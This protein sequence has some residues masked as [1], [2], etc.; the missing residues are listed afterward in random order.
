[1]GST[2]RG[3]FEL[4]DRASNTLRKIEA[5][6]KKTQAAVVGVGAALDAQQASSVDSAKGLEKHDAALRKVSG[7]SGD[8]QKMSTRQ[9]TSEQKLTRETSKGTAELRRRDQELVKLR[10]TWGDYSKTTADMHRVGGLGALAGGILGTVGGPVGMFA[11]AV[12]G[13]AVGAGS[14]S[15]IGQFLQ[16]EQAAKHVKMAV[17]EMGK[18]FAVAGNAISLLKLGVVV[19][20]IA[21]LIASVTALGGGLIAF[22]PQ[23]ATLGNALYGLP[24]AFSA[25]IQGM[26]TFKLAI[27]GVSSAIGAA[28]Q[29]QNNW[30]IDQ[31]QFGLQVQQSQDSI[32]ASTVNL[33]NAIFAQNQAQAQLTATRRDAAR[34]LVDMEF[35]A[36]SAVLA[37]TQ[38]GLNIMQARQQLQ[39]DMSS[40]GTSQ[41]TVMQD[42]LGLQQ[43]ILGAQKQQVDTNRANKDLQLAKSGAPSSDVVMK[44]KEAHQALKMAMF[45][46]NEAQKQLTIAQKQYA[47]QIKLGNAGQSA[48][49]AQLRQLPASAKQFVQFIRQGGFLKAFMQLRN[50]AGSEFFPGLER[51]L[52]RLKGSLPTITRIV[53][54]TGRVLG[55]MF[56]NVISQLSDPKW[57]K[58]VGDANV[59]IL[60]TFSDAIKHFTSALKPLIVAFQPFIQFLVNAFDKWAKHKDAFYNSAAGAKDLTDKVKKLETAIHHVVHVF[61]DLWDI[62]RNI[63]RVAN[64]ALG[65]T[66]WNGATS[67]LDKLKKWTEDQQRAG[68]KGSLF[69]WFKSL[70]PTLR[71]FK[72]VLEDI[73]KAIIQ[74]S[75]KQGQHGAT[76]LLNNLDKLVKP[77]QTILVNLA[78]QAPTFE[79]IA[80]SM[81]KMAASLTKIHG[82]IPGLIALF[83]GAKTLTFITHLTRAA[84]ALGGL[85]G[86]FKTFQNALKALAGAGVAGMASPGTGITGRFKGLQGASQVSTLNAQWGL[87]SVGGPGS[88]E[89]PLVVMMK[90]STPTPGGDSIVQQAE[91]DAKNAAETGGILGTAK[92][93]FSDFKDVAKVATPPAL[94]AAGL[95]AVG[96]KLT[97]TLS[98]QPSHSSSTQLGANTS[99]G[100]YSPGMGLIHNIS[101]GLTAVGSGI[102]SVLGSPSL[103]GPSVS[104]GQIQK[105]GQ[106]AIAQFT[107]DINGGKMSVHQAMVS[108]LAVVQHDLGTLSPAG[109][110]ILSAAMQQMGAT[111]TQQ[112]TKL[113]QPIDQLNSYIVGAFQNTST[114]VQAVNQNIL[115]NSGKQWVSIGNAI[116]TPMNK[117]VTAVNAAIASIQGSAVSAL[118]GMGYSAA[119]AKKLISA[120]PNAPAGAGVA[121]AVSTNVP[122]LTS[123]GTVGLATG[124]RVMGNNPRDVYALGGNMVGGGELVVNRHQEQDVNNR[125]MRAGEPT[126]G[127]IVSNIK[128]PNWFASGGRI[129]QGVAAALNPYVYPLPGFTI[130]RTDMGVDASAPAGTPILALGDSKL[131]DVLQNWY[132]QQ[133]LLD[134]ALTNGPDQGKYWYVAEQITPVTE[135]IGA[136]FKAGQAV[137]HFAAS[138]TGI[139]MGWAGGP[140]GQT[141]AQSTGVTNANVHDHANT[142]AGLAFSAFLGGL[143]HGQLVSGGPT[144]GTGGS[145]KPF[146][147]PGLT[148][149]QIAGLSGAPLGLAQGA[150][151]LVAGG[152]NSKLKGW[153]KNAPGGSTP[154]A[155]SGGLPTGGGAL[156]SSGGSGTPSAAPISPG[157]SAIPTT[158]TPT[159][160]GSVTPES[161]SIAVLKGLGITPTV[162]NVY[163]MTAWIHQ[164]GGAGP[165]FGTP[166]NIANYNPLNTTQVEPGYSE[167]GAV[168][169]NIGSYVSWK[170]G[171][172]ATIK[173]LSY[174]GYTGVIAALKKG[175]PLSDFSNAVSSS[176]WG[177][178]GINAAGTQ[179]SPKALSTLASSVKANS[180]TITPTVGSG[181][182]ASLGN[183]AAGGSTVRAHPTALTVGSGVAGALAP[184]GSGIGSGVTAALAKYASQGSGHYV[185]PIPGAT[186]ERTDMGLDAAYSTA[187]HPIVAIGDSKVIG[188]SPNWY[189]GQPYV[190]FQFLDGPKKGQNYYIAEAINPTVQAGDIVKAGQQVG[191]YNLGGTG[192]ELGW[193][194]PALGTTLAASLSQYTYDGKVTAAGAAF[195]NFFTALNLALPTNTLPS[196][197]TVFGSFGPLPAQGNPFSLQGFVGTPNIAAVTQAVTAPLVHAS[198]R[199]L[200]GA[201]ATTGVPPGTYVPPPPP[202]PTYTPPAPVVPPHMRYTTT[203]PPPPPP[204][205]PTPTASPVSTIIQHH[206]PLASGGRVGGSN[207]RDVYA[208]GGNMVGGGELVV[209]RHQEQDVNSRLLRAGEPTIGSIVANK[210][211]PHWFAKGGRTGS[212]GTAIAEGALLAGMGVPRDLQKYNHQYPKHLTNTPGATIPPGDIAKIAQWAGMPGWTMSQISHGESSYMPGIVEWPPERGTGPIPTGAQGYGLWQI[213]YARHPG[214]TGLPV[215]PPNPNLMLNPLINAKAAKNL[216]D[217]RGVGQW[218]GKGFMTNANMPYTGRLASGGRVRSAG[219]MA[220]GGSF[221]TSGPTVLGVGERNREQVTVTPLGAGGNRPVH[222]EIHRI[223]VNREGDIQK[224]VDEELRLLAERFETHQ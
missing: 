155:F 14:Q 137:A 3:A 80:V 179:L 91:K 161:F 52:N 72:K 167:T 187:N 81:A 108:V 209:N 65:N 74:M 44:L 156:P 36:K 7:S 116:L 217:S 160:S 102:Q 85:A 103:G 59:K 216:Y 51:G 176:P 206:V 186:L 58:K 120:G 123:V 71:A 196:L 166:N 154:S 124:G 181:V 13:G 20:A 192:L 138:G 109:Q 130:G 23:I 100:T 77:L 214:S 219:W 147:I 201:G 21:P 79:K 223:E 25:A 101:Q 139:E 140:T 164:E 73:G 205:A 212:V 94:V 90:G 11:G 83:A 15:K 48:F 53:R 38:S 203:P 35:A 5:Q 39:Q 208:L 37:E 26:S 158:P 63:G 220:A 200:T 185:N 66:M 169:G 45:G 218:Y 152:F 82:F 89:N 93:L 174:S 127:S 222:I 49:L 215:F 129:G 180:P 125:L 70:L 92:K 76:G 110:K 114:H 190:E 141:L 135:R 113:T 121:Q 75:G 131:V 207:L 17:D 170:Q 146:T 46:A 24:A 143:A 34:E 57:L 67:G 19:T 10:R 96:S 2:V 148:A 204:P 202:A 64:Q 106:N 29:M 150:A 104:A 194:S 111:V 178:G 177:T 210:Q 78:R 69:Q 27:A 132:Q 171:L 175:V 118:I 4:E 213:T 32:Y 55:N 126:I 117:A 62:F 183:S 119:D 133:P 162:A 173:T 197:R 153:G 87:R 8:M 224:I 60:K 41:L 47:L 195:K 68:S 151:N 42:Q 50:A 128:K 134:F 159:I 97:S 105:A 168:Q 221:I 144:G 16:T 61:K 33:S 149:P 9:V 88:L 157:S 84:L 136:A 107:N 188:I 163:D 112:N 182:A 189:K 56:G 99:G 199:V 145:K 122:G 6:A 1:M 184:P 198:S 22:V 193:G 115:T 43:A 30:G 31:A 142:P 211:T 191:T 95:T 98:G 12:A 165:Q 172:Q 40:A 28:L 18:A 54:S 86:T